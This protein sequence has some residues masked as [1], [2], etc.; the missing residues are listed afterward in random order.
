MI[1]SGKLIYNIL[2]LVSVHFDCI[3]RYCKEDTDVSL[4]IRFYEIHWNHPKDFEDDF[5]VSSY[6]YFV[7]K[8]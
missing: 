1:F 7:S 2:T 5:E 4:K 6:T 8:F 3:R